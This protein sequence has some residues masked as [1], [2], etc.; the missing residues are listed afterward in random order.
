MG[1]RSIN[2]T[3]IIIIIIIIIKFPVHAFRVQGKGSVSV[4]YT[5]RGMIQQT[6]VPW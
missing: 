1:L 6:F 5:V 4:V 3:I 2:D